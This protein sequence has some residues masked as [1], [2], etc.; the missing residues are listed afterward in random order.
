MSSSNI[1][2]IVSANPTLQTLKPHD[3]Q[4]IQKIQDNFQ[5]LNKKVQ[6]LVNIVNEIPM[7]TSSP[8]RVT[9]W[10]KSYSDFAKNSTNSDWITLIT[11]PYPD[12][13]IQCE[14]LLYIV[15]TA[16]TGTTSCQ[17][18]TEI[19]D[20]LSLVSHEVIGEPAG[21]DQGADHGW[22][23]FQ[24]AGEVNFATT[25]LP[26]TTDGTPANG[27]VMRIKCTTGPENTEALTAGELW[28]FLV[29]TLIDLTPPQGL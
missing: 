21:F 7:D 1:N 12:A 6:S 17:F 14:R 22:H 11:N 18:E 4:S 26:G 15:K 10:L 20:T 25:Y 9:R 23:D 13:A 8:R 16:F 3:K 28:I 29:W 2:G 27:G 24:W 5:F 19:G